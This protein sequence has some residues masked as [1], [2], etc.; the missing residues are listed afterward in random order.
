MFIYKI[1]PF[2]LR[3]DLLITQMH[4]KVKKIKKRIELFI[5]S[6]IKTMSIKWS[7]RHCNESWHKQLKVLYPSICLHQVHMCV[8]VLTNRKLLYSL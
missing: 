3:T 2:F 5:F 7:L 6:H 4:F 1:N 8:V